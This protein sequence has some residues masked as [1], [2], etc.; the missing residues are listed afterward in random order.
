MHIGNASKPG[1]KLNTLPSFFGEMEI[2]ELL[3]ITAVGF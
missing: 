1:T 3:I 2:F